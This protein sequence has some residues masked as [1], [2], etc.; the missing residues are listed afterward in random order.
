MMRKKRGSSL[1]SV[2]ILSFLLITVGTAMVSMTVGDYKMRMTESTRIKNLYSSESGLDVAYDILVKTFDAAATYGVNK[3]EIFK[4]SDDFIINVAK[5]LKDQ[6]A[7]L[8]NDIKDIRNGNSD[9]KEEQIKE[10]NKQIDSLN[11]Q[12]KIEEDAAIDACFKTNF[13]DFVYMNE[14]QEDISKIN[15]VANKDELRK[16]VKYKEYI[17]DVNKIT[18]SERYEDVIFNTEG[19][20]SISLFVDN[21]TE[22]DN[23]GITYETIDADSQNGREYSTRKYTIKITSK[24]STRDTNGTTERKLQSIYEVTV[25]DY[26]DVAFSESNVELPKYTFL[27]DNALLIGGNMKITDANFVVNG[28]I[29]VEGNGYDDIDAGVQTRAYDK[30]NGGIVLDAGS[31]KNVTFTGDVVTGKTFNLRNNVNTIINGNLYAMNVYAG[32]ERATDTPSKN[33]SLQVKINNNNGGNVTVDNDITLNADATSITMD[34]FYGVNDRKRDTTGSV[35]TSDK[36]LGRISSSIIVNEHTGSSITINTEAYIMGV[37]HINTANGYST[38]ESTGV[39]GNYIAYAVPDPSNPS[40]EPI[41]DEPLELFNII[42]KSKY[43]INYW[44]GK[45]IDSGGIHLP[46]NTY[47]YGAIIVDEGGKYKADNGKPPDSTVVNNKKKEFASKVYNVRGAMLTDAQKQELYDSL[48]D[49]KDEVSDIMYMD[50]ADEGY[51]KINQMFFEKYGNVTDVPDEQNNNEKTIFSDKNIKITEGDKDEIVRDGD[52]GIIIKVSAGKTLNAF[53]ATSK[54]ITVE[55][56]VNIQGNIIAEGDLNVSGVEGKTI[57]YNPDLS[58]RIQASNVE[59]FNSVFG[60][61]REDSHGV[62]SSEANINVQYDI[63]KFIKNRLW[64]IVK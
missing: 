63:N 9:R 37:A 13:N 35:G 60:H 59:L 34:R 45:N 52:N 53:I 17:K 2:A 12:I 22:E 20:N 39:R 32:S 44:K 10:K 3:V 57:T 14:P 11:K 21:E 18:K 24:F 31:S 36:P 6:V 46:S 4:L 16:C 42:D 49:G 51:T 27:N 56:N 43:F 33:S 50:G 25:P 54:N 28:N 62:S 26:K 7:S 61:I 55:G 47:S 5:D 64:K 38:G 58:K 48:G 29:F 19:N 1:V 41:Y 40:E 23:G 30:Y 8:K 15:T